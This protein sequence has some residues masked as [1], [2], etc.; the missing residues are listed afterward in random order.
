MAIPAPTNEA[1]LE[2]VT[3]ALAEVQAR[4]GLLLLFGSWR[5]GMR[6]PIPTSICWW[7]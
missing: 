7:W 4:P 3:A 5:G 2:A 6:G 1:D